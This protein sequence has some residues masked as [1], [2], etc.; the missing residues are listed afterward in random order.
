MRLRIVIETSVFHVSKKLT[1]TF[2]CE[3]IV[4]WRGHF[5]A[6]EDTKSVNLSVNGGTGQLLMGIESTTL[7]L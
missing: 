6:T 4:L 2:S 7:I 1:S 5:T 3:N